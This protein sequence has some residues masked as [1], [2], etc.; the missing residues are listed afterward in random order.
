MLKE[1]QKHVSQT[2]VSIEREVIRQK[3]EMAWSIGKSIS[4]HLKKNSVIEKS[5]YGKQLF[6]HLQNDIGIDQ[7]TLYRMCA[8]YKSYPF[9]P[10]SSDRVNWSHY[11]LLSGITKK[12]ER[13]YLEDLVSER[14][15]SVA[16]LRHEIAKS[17]SAKATPAETTPEKQALPEQIKLAAPRR[18]KL[19]CYQLVTPAGADKKYLDCGF[20]IYREVSE[21][22]PDDALIVASVSK[23]KGYVLHKSDLSKKQ[24]FTYKAWLKRVVDGDTIHAV[25]DLGFGILHEE[26]LRLT[27][28]NA[29]ESASKAGAFSS[30]ELEK[31]LAQYSCFVV[32]TSSTDTYN[33]YLADIFLPQQADEDLQQTATAGIYLSQL[34]LECGLVQPYL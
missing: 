20:K 8:F 9:L 15:L 10:K 4:Q 5:S 17:K 31:I 3:V 28:I 25:L 13:K 14:N 7:S 2:Q 11:Q 34:L 26:I 16:Q 18:G 22:L 30:A 21:K 6:L 23:G 29:P 24:I 12:Q 33:R 27:A 19:F 32:R 1:L